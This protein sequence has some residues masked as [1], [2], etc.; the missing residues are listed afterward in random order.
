MH[1]YVLFSYYVNN[2]LSYLLFQKR[3]LGLWLDHEYR[4]EEWSISIYLDQL[5]SV[6]RTLQ[7]PATTCRLPR[8][9]KTYYKFKASEMRVLL[10]FGPVV[11]KNILKKKYYANLMKLVVM[12]HLSENRQVHHSYINII[13]RLGQS[14]TIE[15]SNLYGNRHCVQVIHS[16]VHI[17]DT[18]RDFGPL[19]TFSTFQ[20]KNEL[21]NN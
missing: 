15:F 21:G 2:I 12:M 6:F 14:F 11:F 1:L 3:L 19:H 4:F 17:S 16:L 8:S 13:Q 18:V 20:F 7:I 10:L 9:L 5:Q